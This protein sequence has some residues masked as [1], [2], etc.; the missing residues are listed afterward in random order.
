M[1]RREF[2]GLVGGAAAWPL[3]A[4]AQQRPPIPVVGFLSQ[5]PPR[6]DS[7]FVAAFRE[8]LA[9][10]GLVEGRNV[11]IE[12]RWANGQLS[13]LQGLAEDLVRLQVAVIVAIDS[14]P[15][16]SQRNRTSHRFLREVGRGFF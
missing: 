14:S 6:P 2:V 1:R 7:E 15:G 5:S 8:G 3:A 4:R 11:A 13:Q 9:S 12:Y 10:A 16:A